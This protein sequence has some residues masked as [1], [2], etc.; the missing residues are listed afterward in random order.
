MLLAGVFRTLPAQEAG[1]AGASQAAAAGF[2]AAMGVGA[3]TMD[4]QTWTQISLRPEIPIGKLGL[5]LDLTLYFDEEGNV[6]SQDWDEPRDI[7]DKIY[8]VRWGHR[9][10]PVYVKAGAL[11]NVSLG[12]G[13]LVR[14][15]ANSIEYPSVRRVGAEFDLRIGRPQIEGFLANFREIDEPGLLGLRGSYPV[16]GKLRLGAGLVY[17]GNL[18]AG[19]RDADDDGVPDELDRFPDH[20]DHTEWQLWDDLQDGMDPGLWERL[21]ESPSYPGDDWL[22]GGPADYSDAQESIQA[23][24]FD[25]SYELLPKLDIYLQWAMF[26]SYGS[27]YAPGLVYRPFNWLTMGAEY[28]VWG[29]EFIGEF[30]DSSYD[31]ER[32]FFLDDGLGGGLLLTKKSLLEGAPAMNGW[33]ADARMNI[34]NILKVY[35]AYNTMKPTGGGEDWNSLWGSAGLNLARIPKLSELSVYYRQIGVESLFKLKTE[36]T[37]HGYKLGYEI[38]PGV[39]LR[40]HWRTTYVDANGDGEIRGDAEQNRT[41]AVETVFRLGG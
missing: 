33:F 10:D 11:D 13:I 23:Y 39:D 41:F 16:L 27:G 35:A 7:I 24:S 28:R 26:N 1:D 21:R 18:Y 38:S 2:S 29:E 22:A 3:V 9:G 32:V 17:D 37:V 31:L 15:Y 40:L 6:R 4:G 19:M 36:S 20:S 30:F 34:F 25:I 12:Y 14:N 8:Y 5:A